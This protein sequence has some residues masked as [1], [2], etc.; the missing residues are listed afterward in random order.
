MFCCSTN[1]PTHKKSTQIKIQHQSFD[2]SINQELD[3]QQIATPPQ[4]P[5]KLMKNPP[6]Q[7]KFFGQTTKSE[8]KLRDSK[9]IQPIRNIQHKAQNPFK[10]FE[11][12]KL[13][14]I[15]GNTEFLAVKES[16]TLLINKLTA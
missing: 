6:P 14:N 7:Q 5:K 15:N 9:L 1:K 13:L 2:Q 8:S 12:Y 4:V 3:N 11:T 16:Y 10:K